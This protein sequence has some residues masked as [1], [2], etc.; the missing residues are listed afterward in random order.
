MSTTDDPH[1]GEFPDPD[2]AA[3]P[4]PSELGDYS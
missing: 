3:P 2:E 4:E 1:A